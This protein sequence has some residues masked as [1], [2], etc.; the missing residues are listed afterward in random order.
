MRIGQEWVYIGS[1]NRVTITDITDTI[2]MVE[3]LF[4]NDSAKMYTMDRLAIEF[5]PY[6]AEGQ[7]WN[8]LIGPVTIMGIANDRIIYNRDGEEWNTP[9][10]E[11]F[12]TA[13]RLL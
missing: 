9:K 5:E 3:V 11:F 2:G 1:Q 6:A 10:K 7:T 13:T 4:G 8:F 12:K